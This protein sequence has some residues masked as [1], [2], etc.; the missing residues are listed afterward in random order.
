[1]ELYKHPMYDQIKETHS[2]VAPFNVKLILPAT[3]TPTQWHAPDLSK[4]V[5]CPD[6]MIHIPLDHPV[7][8]Y[9]PI[10]MVKGYIYS[11]FYWQKVAKGPLF[12]EPKWPEVMIQWDEN[13]G[14]E[15]AWDEP[16]RELSQDDL[17]NYRFSAHAILGK[18]ETIESEEGEVIKH[19]LMLMIKTPNNF[20]SRFGL[21][22]LGSLPVNFEVGGE[23]SCNEAI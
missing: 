18:L 15:I 6:V 23:G 1:M 2:G 5:T 13:D 4:I 14:S 3:P 22:H 19:K 17:D 8:K 20:Y 9:I 16:Y 10:G 11:A 12:N 7:L 21:A